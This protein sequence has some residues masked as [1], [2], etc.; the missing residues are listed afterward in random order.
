MSSDHALL[1]A[2]IPEEILS[3]IES[4]GISRRDFIKF[5]TM[6]TAALA[7]PVGMVGKVA[8]AVAD[9]RVPVIWVEYQSCSGDSE[10]L[11]RANLV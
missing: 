7:L 8:A 1:P 6:T 11:L 5:C 2:M 4:R 10:A 9:A 3:R